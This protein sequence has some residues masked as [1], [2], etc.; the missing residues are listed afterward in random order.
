MFRVCA[1]TES[2]HFQNEVCRTNGSLGKVIPVAMLDIVE[3]SLGIITA[4][5]PALTAYI[6]KYVLTMRAFKFF[7]SSFWELIAEF[8]GSGA[9]S[10]LKGKNSSPGRPLSSSRRCPKM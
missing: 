1:K 4:S 5:L 3:L 2:F 8:K 9:I 6:A 7:W 10:I